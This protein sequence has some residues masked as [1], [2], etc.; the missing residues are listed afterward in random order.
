MCKYTHTSIHSYVMPTYR[1]LLLLLLL[2]LLVQMLMLQQ[3][4]RLILP[5]FSN[6]NLL[7][8]S[9][10]KCSIVS[11]FENLCLLALLRYRSLL[12]LPALPSLQLLNT[13]APTAKERVQE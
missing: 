6:V 10:Y 2:E 12:P 4:C 9:L 1:L 11:T 13:H 8:H 5:A 3:G 7:A